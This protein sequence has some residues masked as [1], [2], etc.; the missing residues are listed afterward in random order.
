[1]LTSPTPLSHPVLSPRLLR[2]NTTTDNATKFTEAN[3]E[4]VVRVIPL[5]S[6]GEGTLPRRSAAGWPL[7]W[8][9]ILV[10]DSGEGMPLDKQARLFTPFYQ[11]TDG[12]GRPSKAGGTGASWGVACAAGN[13]GPVGRRRKAFSRIG[14]AFIC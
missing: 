13:E 5:E 3:G 11:I 6:K 7:T 12:R 9:S 4:V 10:R 8:V 2:W 14:C 1:M